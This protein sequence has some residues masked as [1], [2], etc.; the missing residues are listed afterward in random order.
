VPDYEE[1]MPATLTGCQGRIEFVKVNF[2]YMAND[3][4][5]FVMKDFV[6]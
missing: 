5:N 2:S 4:E 6:L 3:K 1:K